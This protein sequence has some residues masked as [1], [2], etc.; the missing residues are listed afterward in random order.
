MPDHKTT[1]TNQHATTGSP[2]F[3]HSIA[4]ALLGSAAPRHDHDPIAQAMH[5]PRRFSIR[6]EFSGGEWEGVAGLIGTDTE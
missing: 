6:E 4:S 2:T 1:N 5:G 3:L